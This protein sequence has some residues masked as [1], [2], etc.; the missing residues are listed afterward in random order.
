MKLAES[1]RISWR[2]ITGHKLRS[3]LTTLGIV[4]G[5]GAVI[6]FMVLGGGFEADILGDVEDEEEPVIQVITQTTPEDGFGIQFIQTPIYTE[7]DVERV[8]EIDGVAYVAPEASIPASQLRYGD[9]QLLSSGGFGGEFS[10]DATTEDWFEDEFVTMVEGDV[11][12]NENEAVVNERLLAQFD[13]ELS[14]GDEVHVRLDGSTDTTFE[15]SGIV[16]DDVGDIVQP[17]VYVPLEPH[18]RTTID[19][20]G[21]GEERAFTSLVVSGEEFD[22]LSALQKDVEEYFESESDAGQLKDDHHT[23]AVQTVDDIVEQV[24][25]II[26]QLTLFIGGI[27]AISLVVGSRGIANIMRVSATERTRE[28]GIMKAVGARKRDI[29][30]LFLVESLIL[31]VIGAIFGVLVGIG[32]GYL[33]VSLAGWP[34][35]YPTNWIIIAVA[36]GIVVGVLSGLY[37]AWRAAKVDPIEALRHE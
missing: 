7:S 6:V 13:E 25:D 21:G 29:V 19:A 35:A 33:A 10:V 37:P 8:A 23:I 31:G 32:L 2:A 9:E 20:P 14:V 24:G 16:D 17:T 11:F 4:I 27:A 5:V 26:D 34:M 1:F 12:E 3:T 36:V 22:E 28:I 15:V 18:Y 30:Q